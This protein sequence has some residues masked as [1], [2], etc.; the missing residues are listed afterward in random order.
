M[1]YVNLGFCNYFMAGVDSI[2]REVG[3]PDKC[4]GRRRCVRTELL[5]S[6]FSF[7]CA[8]AWAW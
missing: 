3:L 7:V 4:R 1:V 8:Y 6:F 5:I 2:R